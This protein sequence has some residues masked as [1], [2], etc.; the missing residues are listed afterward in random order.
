MIIKAKHNWFLDPFF[1][2]YVIRKMKRSFHS[3]QIEGEMKDKNLPILLV[4]NHISWWDGIWTLHLNQQLFHR[5]YHFMMLETMLQKNWY[6]KYTGGFSVDK[7]SKSIIE[8]L[9][10]TAELL[11]DKNNMVLM[12]PQGEIE[13]MHNHNFRFEKGIEKILQRTKNDVQLIFVANIVD[14]HSHAKPSL[15]LYIADFTGSFN[16]AEIEKKYNV[17]YQKSLET[18]LKRKS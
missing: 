10:Y 2:F 14:Y 9:N 8:T 3:V 17:F 12:F 6:F 4:C 1:R 7:S 15:Y 18:Q 11:S 13:S 16:T 5:K